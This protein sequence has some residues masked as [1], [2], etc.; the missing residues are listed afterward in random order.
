[1]NRVFKAEYT[2]GSSFKP[3]IMAMALK[4]GTIALGQEIDCEGGS[5]RI[6]GRTVTDTHVDYRWLD[7]AGVLIKSSNIGMSKI[8]LG[9]VPDDTPK[10]GAAFRPIWNTL[11]LL[12]FG[13]YP[14]IFDEDFESPGKMTDL[15]RW[16]STYTLVSLSFGNE[17]AVTPIQMAS[18]FSVL[19]NNGLYTPPRL[20]ERMEAPDGSTIDLPTSP[21]YRVFPESVCR[22]VREMLVRVVEEG[23]GKRARI[24]GIQ[25]AGKT[26]TAEKLP[27]RE[28][29]TSSFIA[30]APAEQPALLVLVVVDE[31]QGQ[32]YASQ[33]AAPSVKAILERGLAYR[34]IITQSDACAAWREGACNERL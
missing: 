18:A 21:A 7:P 27:Q 31:P 9:L 19:A 26:G 6:G 10:G 24:P 5:H 30:F 15:A 28:E 12:G 8:V 14:G 25:V 3:L 17:I 16:T 29:V 1:M 4:R 33:V 11:T 13:R 23:S 20:I 2:P 22:D 32:H 34:G